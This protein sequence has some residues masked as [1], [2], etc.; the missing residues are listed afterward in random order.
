MVILTEISES[1]SS[2]NQ[3]YDVFLSFRGADTRNNFTDHLQNALV[4][5]NLKTFLD[6]EEIHTGLYLKPELEDAIK[7]SRASVI[8]LS[9][10]YASST[11]CLDELV[12]IL[13]QHK[14]CG[15]IVIPIFYHVEPTDLRKQQNSFKVA[16]DEHKKKMEAESDLGK[17]SVLAKKI[18]KWKEALTKVA[19]LKGLDAK[20]RPEVKFIKEIIEDIYRKLDGTISSSLPL[21]VGMDDSIDFLTS[22]LKDVSSHRVDILTISGMSGIGK[23]SVA[24]HV[25]KLHRHK[26]D[27]SCFLE[28]I[29]LSC[30]QFNGMLGLQKQLLGSVL[31]TSP[32]HV[33][34]VSDYTSH[35]ESALSRKK[36]FLVLDDIDNVNQLNELLGNKDHHPGSKIIITAKNASFTERYALFNLQVKPK[37]IEHKPIEHRLERLDE[38]ASQKL[39]FLHAFKCEEPKVG[40]M[41]VSKDVVKYCGGHP[42]A[43]KLLGNYLH[44]KSVAYWEACINGLKKGEE[45][46]LFDI[47]D[48]LKKIFDKLHKNDKELFKYIACFFVGMKR[49]ITETILNACDLNAT[50][51]ISHLIDRCLLDIG[52]N[53]ELTMHSLIHEMGIHVVDDES[54]NPEERSR[55][56]RHTDSYKVLKNKTGTEN[57]K[58]LSLDINIIQKGKLHKSLFKLETDALSRMDKLMLLQLNNVQLEGSYEKFPKKLRWLCMQWFPLESLPSGFPMKKLVALDLSYSSITSFNMCSINPQPPLLGSLKILDVSFCKQLRSLGDFSKFYKLERLTATYCI[59]LIEICESIELCSELVFLDLSYCTKLEKLLLKKLEKVKTLVLDGCI[60]GES[61]IESRDMDSLEMLNLNNISVNSQTSS[62]SIVLATRRNL[63]FFE[64]SFPYSLV[65]LSLKN[66]NLTNESF[67]V[68]LSSLSMLKELHLD[69]NPIVSMPSC[70]STLPRLKILGMI[71]CFKLTSV[72]HPPPTLTGLR[73]EACQVLKKVV[74]NPEMT[75]MLFS[76][77]SCYPSSSL[78]MVIEGALKVQPMEDVE[79]RVLCALRWSNLDYTIYKCTMYYEFGIFSTIYE[80]KEMPNWISDIRENGPSISFTI[81]SSPNKNLT[82]LNMCC[83]LFTDPDIKLKMP[84]IK[85]SNITR[86]CTW[87]YIHYMGPHTFLPGEYSIY[88]SHWMF[89]KNDMEPGD[90]VTI[91]MLTWRV[92]GE[93]PTL[94]CGISFVYDD[95]NQEVLFK[96]FSPKKSNLHD[97]AIEVTENEIKESGTSTSEGV[98]RTNKPDARHTEESSTTNMIFETS[99]HHPCHFFGLAKQAFLKCLGI[100]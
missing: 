5:A 12:L 73:T 20:D 1:S 6:N 26:F 70:V 18:E 30:A 50:I 72:K 42:M 91:N 64:V 24:N 39:L 2:G 40:Y 85:I 44:Q 33:D 100:D 47:K 62:S 52:R 88:I 13:E 16:M 49:D 4:G 99:T 48:I 66:N 71:A 58:G 15:Q 93:D 19:D 41:E 11:W 22:W 61:Q 87:M 84:M 83:V 75:P 97:P 31:K 86:N 9:K 27:A 38:D 77:T 63:N 7:A 17:K 28:K 21:L 36:V 56:W 96:A 23:T 55:L 35:I 79:K 51:G 34:R 80:G 68:D 69:M 60:F 59:S 43:L 3:K 95:G 74:F 37:T 82:G 57:I 65:T 81:P 53:A 46:A 10:N 92:D 90:H 94:E 25:Y 32:V 76:M 54:E 89:T 78:P 67:P 45:E 98:Q 8:V 14:T 29:S